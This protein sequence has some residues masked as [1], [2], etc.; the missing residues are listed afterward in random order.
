MKI[1]KVELRDITTHKNTSI[2]FTDGVNV[3]LGLNGSGKSTVLD[4]IGFVLFDYLSGNQDS[5]VNNDP[6]IKTGKAIVYMIGADGKEY[7]VERKVG[8]SSYAVK[9]AETGVALSMINRKSDLIGWLKEQL[10][11]DKNYDLDTIFRNSIGVEQGTFT[12]PFLETESIRKQIFDPILKIDVYEDL[13]GKLRPVINEFNEDLKNTEND[14][15]RLEG[16]LSS[17]EDV[18]QNFDEKEKINEKL[19]LEIEELDKKYDK[20]RENFNRLKK[21]NE[22]LKAASNRLEVKKNKNNTWKQTLSGLEEDI[23]KAEKSAKICKDHKKGYKKYKDLE[24]KRKS[25]AEEIKKL[26]KKAEKYEILLRKKERLDAKMQNCK[27][28]IKKLE[29]ETK[30][31]EQ[32]SEFEEKNKA[33]TEKETTLTK[34]KHELGSLKKQIEKLTKQKQE[35]DSEISKLEKELKDLPDTSDLESKIELKTTKIEEMQ[36]S[37]TKLA[38][39]LENYKKNKKAAKGGNCPILNEPCKNIEGDSLEEYF[40]KLIDSLKPEISEI[41]QSIKVLKGQKKEMEEKL[42]AVRTLDA[43]KPLLTEKKKQRKKLDKEIE[44]NVQSVSELD[45][46]KTK[47]DEVKKEKADLK[48]KLEELAVKKDKL[49]QLPKEQEKKEKIKAETQPLEKNLEKLKPEVKRLS[50]EK[51]NLNKIETSMKQTKDSH[52]LYIKNKQTAETL[53]AKRKESSELSKKI[54]EM[55]REISE[56]QSKITDLTKKIDPEEFREVE[57]QKDELH[58]DL[59]E[60]QGQKSQ[61]DQEI[62]RLKASL[63]KFREKEKEM[64]ELQNKHVKLDA[65]IT[66]TK[67]LRDWYREA[68]KKIR[69]AMTA[70]ISH[71]ASDILQEIMDDPTVMVEWDTTYNAILDSTDLPEREFKQLSGGEQMSV[72]LSIRM[73]LLKSLSKIDIA[74]FDEPTTNLDYEKKRNLA[75]CIRNISGFSQ[76]FVISHDDTFE[77]LAHNVLRFEIDEN[78]KTTIN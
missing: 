8:Q 26:E 62:E 76:L 77:D 56:V 71:K 65:Q 52:D 75:N 12:S 28:T 68:G 29:K 1:T 50:D 17:K 70:E 11:I 39:N 58:G 48:P 78:N 72:A 69:K 47:L 5:Y 59:K 3:F 24:T 42:K 22:E 38:S 37:Y 20:A 46:I 36:S 21:L 49:K 25:L 34:K 23:K 19:K 74:F 64:V 15:S 13:H 6:K 9:E 27:D 53:E 4:M 35:L 7:S 18:E 67:N 60:K 14:L 51:E 32:Y 66:F 54:E 73:A 10:Q 61:I 2:E 33:L 45:S 43:K 63:Q 41:E 55:K 16:E 30:D 57:K 31:I 40:K 44:K